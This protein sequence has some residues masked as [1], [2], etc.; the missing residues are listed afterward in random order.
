MVFWYKWKA[1]NSA[2]DGFV[3]FIVFF[4]KQFICSSNKYVQYMGSDYSLG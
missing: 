1:D 4:K 2:A 3:S